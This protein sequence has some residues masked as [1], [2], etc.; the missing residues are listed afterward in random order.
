MYEVSHYG[1]IVANQDFHHF[2]KQSPNAHKNYV[3][4]IL[5]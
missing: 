5:I 4:N 1:D 3:V 2:E